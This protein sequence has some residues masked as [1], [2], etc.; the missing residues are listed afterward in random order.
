MQV[1]KYID[2]L[3][4]YYVIMDNQLPIKAE[5]NPKEDYFKLQAL[6][7]SYQ[8]QWNQ[9]LKELSTSGRFGRIK[10]LYG[11]NH[12][13]K[14]VLHVNAP[15]DG[16]VLLVSMIGNQIGMYYSDFNNKPNT[17]IST[18][19]YKDYVSYYPFSHK[20]EELARFALDLA[21]KYFP[22]FDKFDN[23]H[24]SIP[25]CVDMSENQFD[26]KDLFQAIFSTSIHPVL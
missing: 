14:V 18:S 1:E 16:I 13:F 20:Q 5:L 3:S 7:D 25:Y 11:S 26:K 12:S 15:T 9:F 19:E 8:N 10:E 21:W 17:T 24:A 4:R 23:T 2:L 6:T 22:A